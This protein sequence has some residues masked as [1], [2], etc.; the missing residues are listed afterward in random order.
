MDDSPAIYIQDSASSAKF[1]PYKPGTTI[2]LTQA[3]GATP[4]VK[5]GSGDAN[6]KVRLKGDAVIVAVDASGNKAT[7]SCLV[8]PPPK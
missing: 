4:E 6:W 5:P 2:K 3:P 1:G 8:P 7:A